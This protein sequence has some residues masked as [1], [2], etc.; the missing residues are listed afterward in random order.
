MNI[1]P[2]EKF[3]ETIKLLLPSEKSVASWLLNVLPLGKEAIYRRIY[4][5]TSF[6]LD[7][8]ILIAQKLNISLD[9]L[10]QNNVTI[11]KLNMQEESKPEESYFQLLNEQTVYFQ[12]LSHSENSSVY[13]AFNTIPYTFPLNYELISKFQVYKYVF[14]FIA[15]YRQMI[16][17]AKYTVSDEMK[18]YQHKCREALSNVKNTQY[19]LNKRIFKFFAEDISHLHKMGK[20]NDLEKEQLKQEI[21]SLID[22]LEMICTSGQR[23]YRGNS[24]DIYLSNM[25]FETSHIYYESD[26]VCVTLLRLFTIYGLHSKNS[27]VCLKQKE[28]FEAIRHTS[29]RISQSDI[30]LR[31]K[32]FSAQRKEIESVL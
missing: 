10:Y 14:N 4:G 3:I 26:D 24:V 23:K 28:C 15:P 19:I 32:Y 18:S 27:N 1:I 9:R 17:L 5:E 2:N 20:V 7:E 12:S 21:L 11:I 31:K 6:S 8:A 13:G 29:T 30:L 16:P 25:H 22:E